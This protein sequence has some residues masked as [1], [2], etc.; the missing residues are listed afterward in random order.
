MR[1][2]LRRH[3]NACIRPECVLCADLRVQ[4]RISC[5]GLPS[6][7]W[8]KVSKT[9][10]QPSPVLTL[11]SLITMARGETY[12]V[13][14]EIISFLFASPDEPFRL[15]VHFDMYRDLMVPHLDTWVCEDEALARKLAWSDG[16][17]RISFFCLHFLRLFRGRL[18]GLS[19]EDLANFRILRARCRELM[20]GLRGLI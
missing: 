13:P 15:H 16:A 4:F 10:L 6:S 14:I 12:P 3:L 7:F 17:S 2:G 20:D 19:S 5:P 1:S 9:S 11:L 18:S 8:A